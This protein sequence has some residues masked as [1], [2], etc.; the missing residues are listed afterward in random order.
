[1]AQRPGRGALQRQHLHPVERVGG[2]VVLVAAERDEQPVRHELDVLAHQRAVHADQ[3]DRQRLGD[4]L[5]LD[6][7]RLGHDRQQPLAGQLGVQQPARARARAARGRP[8]AV[9]A[10]GC[11]HPPARSVRWERV[12]S[13]SASLSK[14]PL[15]ASEQPPLHC[16]LQG[17]PAPERV[18]QRRCGANAVRHP[19]EPVWC[20]RVA[21]AAPAGA[22]RRSA[23]A[24]GTG[25]RTSRAGRRSRNAGPRR[26]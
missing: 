12:C 23:R 6:R 22:L 8:A 5:A 4:E 21:R 13:A 9:R 1:V 14:R 11:A 7:D 18:L 15:S 20:G 16:P 24:R 19:S 3:V 26:G 10:A 25:A 2:R 17:R